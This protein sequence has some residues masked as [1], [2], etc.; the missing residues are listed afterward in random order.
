GLAAPH[1]LLSY[2]LGH[3][4]G[5]T[6]RRYHEHY[7]DKIGGDPSRHA[8]DGIASAHDIV[9]CKHPI[10]AEDIVPDPLPRALWLDQLDGV[11]LADYSREPSP[12]PCFVRPGVRKTLAV[13]GA[14]VVVA[15]QVDGLAGQRWATSLNLA[16]PSCDGFLGRYVLADG[17][18]A[19]GFGQPLALPEATWL[20]LEDGVLGG[21]LE[22]QTSIPA[23]IVAR[24]MH[25][26]SQ[27]EAGFEKIMQAVEIRFAWIIPA[28]RCTLQLQLTIEPAQP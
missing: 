22:L 15:W 13:N 28:D 16:M 11:D 25:T 8:G 23:E 2:R 5:D 19:G 26:V 12:E 3:N 4:F 14:S 9:R 6:L 18:I 1:E 20:V 10:A 21:R 24:A 17:S 27:S 7:H